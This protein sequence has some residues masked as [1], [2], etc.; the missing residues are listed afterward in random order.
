MPEGDSI[1]RLAMRLK[2]L[3]GREI[4]YSQFRTPALATA[5]LTGRTI[6]R[7]W[8][9]GKHLLW[10]CSGVVLH[11]HLRMEGTWR[12]HPVGHRW[13]LPGH[14]AR[15]VIHV[16]GGVELVGH[17][18]GMVDLWPSVD[19]GRRLGW[20]G[21]DLL[22]DDWSALG[23]WHPTGRDEA[24]ARLRSDPS[25]TIGEALMDQ[26]NLSGIGN[27]YRAEVCFLSGTHPRT[28][29]ASV[30]VGAVVDL[31]AKLMRGNLR[32][33]VRTFTGDHR[34]GLTTFVFGRRQQP[35]RRCGA[36]ILGDTLGGGSSI[37]DPDAGQERLIWWCPACQPLRQA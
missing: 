28:P 22:A 11:T 27:E 30:G 31:A 37:A 18:L 25:R 21:P 14:T 2:P 4:L 29:V 19:L 24:I 6:E 33:P 26:R 13:S 17:D 12:L 20:L 23:R 32:S 1:W 8:A 15:V 3:E 35:C 9:H 36:T 7:V 5:S 16:A 10:D 34:R